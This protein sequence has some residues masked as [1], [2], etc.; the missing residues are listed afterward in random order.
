MD[1]MENCQL[2]GDQ[3]NH[4]NHYNQGNA[5]Q[6]EVWKD[7]PGYEGL[8][9][10]SNLGR[11]KS[12]H[13]N[14]ADKEQVLALRIGRS[15][16]N[17]ID[18]MLCKDGKHTRYKVHRL[19]ATA[20]LPNP[21]NYPHINH[22]DENPMN[23]HVSNLEWCTPSYNL[24]YGNWALHQRLVRGHKVAKLDLNDNIIEVYD[25]IKEAARKNNA[26]DANIHAVL[27][28]KQHKCAGFKWRKV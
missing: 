19:V 26:A 14:K 20:F 12:L 3:V 16:N 6:E 5:E 23:N 10:V 18:V 9:Q 15:R 7:I 17:Y 11:V 24:K 21:N 13:Y 2:N 25:S 22:K 8:Y 28:G 1:Y 27:K 4:P